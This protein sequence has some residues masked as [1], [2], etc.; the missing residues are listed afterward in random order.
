MV[1]REVYALNDNPTYG[2]KL[3]CVKKIPDYIF[4]L[5]E[6]D[7][8]FKDNLAYDSHLSKMRYEDDNVSIE[9]MPDSIRSNLFPF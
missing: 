9:N 6:I 2:S 4:N 3:A 8:P 1:E 5:R 7:V